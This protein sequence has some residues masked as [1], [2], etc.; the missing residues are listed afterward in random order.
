MHV[1]N[2]NKIQLLFQIIFLLMLELFKKNQ[3]MQTLD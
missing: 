2:Y 3:Y 1:I